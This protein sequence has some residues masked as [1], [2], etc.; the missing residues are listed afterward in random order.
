MKGSTVLIRM[1]G[2]ERRE[3]HEA[4]AAAA[5]AGADPYEQP[6]DPAPY[7]ATP[8]PPTASNPNLPYGAGAAGPDAYYPH[9][10]TFP[11]PPGTTAATGPGQPYSPQPY[12][13]ANFP[14]PP[15]TTGA[16]GQDAFVPRRADE[17]VSGI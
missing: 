5:A 12:N 11:P 6:Y 14:P 15:G 9:T 16:V 17:N 13:P 3:R 2:Q 10:N 4:E 8:P 1:S 7:G